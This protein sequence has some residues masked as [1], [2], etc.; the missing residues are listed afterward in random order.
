MVGTLRRFAERV[1]WQRG[2]CAPPSG[3]DLLLTDACNLRCEYCPRWGRRGVMLGREPAGFMDT[4][5]ALALVDQL[6]R[7]CDLPCRI[8]EGYAF[9]DPRGRVHPCP[10]LDMGNA[11]VEPF[12]RVWN[13][14]RYRAFR[15]LVRR[16]GRLPFCQR[17]PD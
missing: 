7:T 1:S 17:C 8:T 9:V 5:S 15:R 14:R 11:F 2:Y 16:H 10:S 13:N 3:V 12:S 6:A 4:G